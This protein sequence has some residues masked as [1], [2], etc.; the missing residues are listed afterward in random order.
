MAMS[1]Y[2]GARLLTTLGPMR[3][4]P[5]VMFSNPAIMRS[6]VD[7]PQPDGPTRIT[8]S[9]SWM[10]I[11]TPWIT[12]VAPKAL[13][14]SLISTDAIPCPIP[15]LIRRYERNDAIGDTRTARFAVKNR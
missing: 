13:R 7:L 11:D 12:G 2:F 4:S 1:R 15:D 5:P 9:P 14:T 10:S 3:I 8:N 6:N